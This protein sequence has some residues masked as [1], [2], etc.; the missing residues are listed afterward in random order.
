L[1]FFEKLAHWILSL[2]TS[3]DEEPRRNIIR[4][5]SYFSCSKYFISFVADA[6]LFAEIVEASENPEVEIATKRFAISTIANFSELNGIFFLQLIIFI[7]IFILQ[8]KTC[9]PRI[10]TVL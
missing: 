1:E 10:T 4:A 5:L 2:D 3:V 9:N 6:N 8:T 7:S